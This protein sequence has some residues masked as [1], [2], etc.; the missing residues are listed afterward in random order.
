MRRMGVNPGDSRERRAPALILTGSGAAADFDCDCQHPTFEA[1][2]SFDCD[3]QS[4]PLTFDNDCHHPD[5]PL[6]LAT[7]AASPGIWPTGPHSAPLPH[8][9]Y[10]SPTPLPADFWL[11]GE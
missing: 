5:L 11:S 10:L 6:A 3:G 1:S 9:L 2:D 4:A 7:S 8:C